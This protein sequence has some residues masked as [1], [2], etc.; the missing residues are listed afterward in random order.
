MQFAWSRTEMVRR[1][2]PEGSLV[3]F[4]LVLLLTMC[5]SLSTV[6]AGWVPGSE[7]LP[8]LALLAALLMAV[9]AVFRAVPWPLALGA[10]LLLAPVAAYLVT[11][12]ALHHAHP[13]DPADP[14]GLLSAWSVRIGNGDAGSDT[15]F[16]LYLLS[17]LFWI[18]GGW[19]SWCVLRWSQPLLGL[20]PGASAFATN[21]LNY[22]ADQ[23]G[24][25]L[26]FL[27][28]TLFLLLWTSYLRSLDHARRSRIKMSSDARWDFW[29]TGI[30]VMA[31]VVALGIF[32]PPL[33]RADRTIDIENGSFRGWAELQQRLNHPVAFGRGNASGTSIGF[34]NEVALAGPL[35][36]TGGVVFT[37]T[38][39]GSNGAT[40]YFRGENLLR[41]VSAS[42]GPEWRYADQG[43]LRQALPKGTAPLYAEEYKAM[44]QASF[45]MQMLKPPAKAP[46]VLFY[47]GQLLKVDRDAV[48]YSSLGFGPT[49]GVNL[50][51]DYTVDRVS[52]LGRAQGSGPYTATV[53]YSNATEDQLRTA[54]SDYPAWV[55]PYRNFGN[56]YAPDASDSLSRLA[57][58]YRS[59]TTLKRIQDLTLSI[60]AGKTTS[61]DQAQAVENYL[62][63]NYQYTLTP[64]VPP[65]D[66]DPLEYFLFTS[67]QGY[68]EYFASAMG[69]MLRSIGIPTRLVQG[70]GPGTFDEKLGRYIVRES[71]AHTWVETYFPQ[72]G[73]IPFEPTADGTYFPIPRGAVASTCTIDLTICDANAGTDTQ[74]VNPATR[75]DQ[76]AGDTGDPTL[77][78]GGLGAK[79]PVAIPT[80]LA[81]LVVLGAAVWLFISRYL[82]PRTVGGIW[83]RTALLSRLAGIETVLAETPLEFGRRLAKEV[84][85][86]S[87]PARALSEQFAVAAYAPPEVAASTREAALE[88]WEELRPL[89]LKR[90]STRFKIA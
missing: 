87:T 5:V 32:L 50:Q 58:N 52:A 15:V 72:F 69:D 26:A 1:Q 84:P 18:V 89:L 44:L 65:R 34:S 16:Y 86:A 53:T 75:P 90:V 79:L 36:R 29:E 33:S 66:V 46:D 56:F 74:T 73:W 24:Y 39:D 80:A 23:N 85:E 48:T 45:K 62:R 68:C 82:R 63:S 6:A 28:V 81:L 42:G 31:V 20:V 17:M 88:S 9:L 25:T 21:V 51:H 47:P 27:V 57:G 76:G 7:V 22:P 37:Y 61:Y 67:K 8:R 41:T 10:G 3:S 64:P 4:G 38:I 13:S 11:A 30:V 49:G 71:D 77:R 43:F 54:G 60:V 2:M 19:L 14:L 35:H 78:N 40:R 59:S 55:G 70:Y 83:R 12:S